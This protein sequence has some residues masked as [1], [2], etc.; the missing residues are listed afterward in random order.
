MAVFIGA[1]LNQAQGRSNV[2]EIYGYDALGTDWREIIEALIMTFGNGPLA[3]L[4]YQSGMFDRWSST[5]FFIS[6]IITFVIVFFIIY[7]VD[8]KR[9]IIKNVTLPQ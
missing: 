9:N 5:P 2:I 4:L 6:G 7:R 8:K 3:F 1:Y